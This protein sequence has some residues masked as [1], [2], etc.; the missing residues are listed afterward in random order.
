MP[1]I[2]LSELVC[3]DSPQAVLEEVRLILG[4]ALPGINTDPVDCAF[5]AA[6]SLFIGE[7]P[8][9]RSCLAKYH[10]LH[11]TTDVFLAMARLIHGCL[12]SG[13]KLSRERVFISLDAAL[14]HDAGYIQ[15]DHDTEGTGAKYTAV[16]VRRS[17][18]FFKKYGQH[19][20]MDLPEIEA[21][22]SM[23]LNTDI[24][25]DVSSIKFQDDECALLG[26]MLGAA[27]LL[28]QMAD[29]TYLEKLLHLY[30][31]FEEGGIGGFENETDLLRKS[32]N[33]FNMIEDRLSAFNVCGDYMRNHF[34]ARWDLDMDLYGK[35]MAR[36]KKYLEKLVKMSD[37]EMLANLRRGNAES[38]A[39]NRTGC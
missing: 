26:Q 12:L 29:R 36:H 1:E 13:A 3:M 6:I 28:A 5:E 17:A 22:M 33:F 35:A 24:K 20:N 16:H 8:G 15:E 10:D 31:E 39:S 19:H 4:K 23:I 30:R 32:L 14:F 37:N 7:Y 11:H 9:Y 21:G 34:R 38:K 18:E 27:D 2:Q 25:T